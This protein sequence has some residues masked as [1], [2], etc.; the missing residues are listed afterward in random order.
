MRTMKKLYFLFVLA[1]CLASCRAD[2]QKVHIECTTDAKATKAVL[3]DLDKA[4]E[5]I[6]DS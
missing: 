1:V 5:T 4:Q 2:A 6:I 3:L